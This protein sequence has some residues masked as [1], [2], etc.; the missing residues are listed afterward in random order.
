[1]L[2]YKAWISYSDYW[3]R[4]S[5]LFF[6]IA[7]TL[8][9]W[10]DCFRR[11]INPWFWWS[12]C[13]VFPETVFLFFVLFHPPCK[14]K[15]LGAQEFIQE[16]H[17]ILIYLLDWFLFS[18]VIKFLKLKLLESIYTFNNSVYSMDDKEAE[19]VDLTYGDEP[20]LT[21]YEAFKEIK[22]TP[23]DV[24]YDLGAGIGRVVFFSSL[25]YKIKAVG[26]EKRRRLVDIALRIKSKLKLKECIIKEGDFLSFPL[27]EATVIFVVTRAFSPSTRY[28]LEEKLVK[29][30]GRRLIV[31]GYPFKNSQFTLFNSKRAIFSWGKDHLWF[32]NIL[33]AQDKGVLQNTIKSKKIGEREEVF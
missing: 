28:A 22:L 11:G 25:Y 18:P 3:F 16:L 15:P 13:I 27:E 1:M 10:Q 33:P 21:L 14:S 29:L 2:F 26:I 4:V 17:K 6:I 12:L 5:L 32:Y 20:F 24:V 7:F 8:W 19:D 9:L 23:E 31:A 30:S